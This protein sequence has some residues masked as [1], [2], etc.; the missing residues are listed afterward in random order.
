[1]IVSSLLQHQSEGVEKLLSKVE[2]KLKLQ[3]SK[4]RSSD[5]KMAA[6]ASNSMDN[7]DATSDA[8]PN[9]AE[10]S[11][12]AP[13]GA[14]EALAL[15]NTLGSDLYLPGEVMRERPNPNPNPNPKILTQ[16]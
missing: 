10:V 9:A 8:T 5:K 1:M 6:S 16:P 3:D 2:P 13:L 7:S 12:V 15:M 11:T 14:A 4:K